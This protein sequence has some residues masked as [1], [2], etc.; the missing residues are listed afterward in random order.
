M[1]LELL[2]DKAR[3]FSS[4]GDPRAYTSAY[5]WH[6]GYRSLVPLGQFVEVRSLTIAGYPD[7]SFE[8]LSGLSKLEELSVV[9]MPKASSLAPISHLHSLRKLALHTLPSWDGSSR[10]TIVESLAPIAALPRLQEL[11]LFGVVPTSHDVGELF[12]SS[13]LV[14]VRVSKYPKAQV[15]RLGER[16][17]AQQGIQG[18]TSPPSAESRP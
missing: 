11:E 4:V 5:I 18:P 8:P 9:H 7:Q 16:F 3:E 17:Q 12:E 1:R 14:S 13:S 15:Q 10:T 6:C 2:R